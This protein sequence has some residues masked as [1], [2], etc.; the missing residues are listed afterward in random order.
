MILS[1]EKTEEYREI[2]KYN[3]SLLFDWRDSNYSLKEFTN[4]LIEGG[5]NIHL[6]VYLK[7]YSYDTITFPHAYK[8]D[9]DIFEIK[10]NDI[11]IG[12][13]K[14]EWGAEDGVNYFVFSLGRVLNSNK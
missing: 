8:T 10:W 5:D 11:F 13:G 9:R 14:K 7:W 2:K 6:W 3:V 1:G 4:K 12:T